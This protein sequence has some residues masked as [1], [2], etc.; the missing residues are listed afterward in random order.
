MV[1]F[2]FIFF[3]YLSSCHEN[4]ESGDDITKQ[5]PKNINIVGA[6]LVNDTLDLKDDSGKWAKTFKVRAG[7][8][9][10]WLVN[11]RDVDDVTN[12]Y[13]KS[14]SDSVFKTPPERIGNSRNWTG[15]VD[16][17]AKSGSIED[18][19]IEWIDTGRVKH[20]YDPKIQVY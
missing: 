9:I 8:T 11:T 3:S 17:G 2:L 20:T 14:G 18:Y 15:T 13:K 4:E 7:K 12:I 1:V 10:R 19:S 5:Q 6:N 16:P